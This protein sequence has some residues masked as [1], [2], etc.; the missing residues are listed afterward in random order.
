MYTSKYDISETCHYHQTKQLAQQIFLQKQQVVKYT[1]EL[2]S[3]CTLQCVLPF[4]V[5]FSGRQ[6]FLRCIP[7][8]LNFIQFILIPVIL[9]LFS[10]SITILSSKLVVLLIFAFSRPLSRSHPAIIRLFSLFLYFIAL[11]FGLSKCSFTFSSLF[12]LEEKIS[13]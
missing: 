2:Y 6:N 8:S 1:C 4:F 9:L 12:F 5:L 7:F 13:H 10:F 3:F 11:T